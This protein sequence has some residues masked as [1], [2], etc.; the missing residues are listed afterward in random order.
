M[1]FPY[2]CA[3]SLS[4]YLR[5]YKSESRLTSHSA[6]I[7]KNSAERAELWRCRLPAYLLWQRTSQNHINS[8]C[9]ATDIA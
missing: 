6:F 2:F 8:R 3:P 4:N 9:R 1:S 7:A 5:N